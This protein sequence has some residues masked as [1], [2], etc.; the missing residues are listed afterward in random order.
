MLCSELM[1]RD[2]K[3]VS[4]REPTARAAEIMRDNDIGFIPVYDENRQKLV[5]TVTDRD[6]AVRLVGEHKPLDTPVRDVMTRNL[7][8]CHANEDV[9]EARELMESHQLSRMIVLDDHEK[10][11]GIISL[12]D[13]SGDDETGETLAVIKES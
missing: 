1:N 5:G 7:I 6:I 8:F 12:G 11:A 9:T 4:E 3:L 2:V 13:L 10:V